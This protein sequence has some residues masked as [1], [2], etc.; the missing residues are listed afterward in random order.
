[1]QGVRYKN[2]Y[3]KSSTPRL[4]TFFDDLKERLE[5]LLVAIMAT[6]SSFN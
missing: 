1:M 4:E 3:P 5:H 2:T 6:N